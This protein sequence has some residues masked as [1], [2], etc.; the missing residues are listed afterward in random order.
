MGSKN[1]K[2]IA[3]R[4]SKDIAV[5]RPKEFTR[6][7]Q[8]AREA[9]MSDE[10]NYDSLRKLGT[11]VLVSLLNGTG[12]F[13]YKNMQ[14]GYM[15]NV[16]EI[17]GETLLEKYVVRHKA[18][19]GCIIG[20]GRVCV[21]NDG[22][23]KGVYGEKMEFA[24]LQALGGDCAN[25]N[26]G[27]IVYEN[28]LCNQYGLD[29]I[30]TGVTVAWAMEC[31][32]RG[33][34]TAG[35]AGGMELEWGDHHVINDLIGKMAR[36]EGFGDVLADGSVF[37][38]KK[39]GKGLKYAF[40]MLGNPQKG[41]D[42]R[43]RMGGALCFFTSTRGSDHLRGMPLIEQY[44]VFPIETYQQ[45]YGIS[46]MGDAR[47][48]VGKAPLVVWNEH[49]CA[50]A[51]ALEV[52]KFPT[53]WLEVFKGLKFKEFAELFSAATGIKA[54]ERS[55]MKVGE[56]IYNVERAYNVREGITRKDEENLPFRWTDEPLPSGPCKGAVI[57]SVEFRKMLDEYYVLRG[58]DVSTG[59]PTREKLEELNLKDVS[60]ELEQLNKL[61]SITLETGKTV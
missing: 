34:I 19:F 22:E 42:M 38:A 41:N 9:I 26:L 57:N 50:I 59:L 44:G 14:E 6:I 40:N 56:R 7:V 13:G 12:T 23:Y 4:G 27:S 39:L 47:S 2:A 30:R 54:T 53:A 61:P 32:Q 29:A 49:L 58:W 25:S 17:S 31:Y 20:C 46:E 24:S 18:C 5:A 51:D 45:L 35:D 52:C 55:M 8:K 28:K 60:A 3:V 36:R 48:R 16:D 10:L 21:V 43:S 11:T 15:E 33:I 1:L 37:A